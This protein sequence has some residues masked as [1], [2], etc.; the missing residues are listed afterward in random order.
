[1][2]NY[3]VFK[4]LCAC[5]QFSRNV[6]NGAAYSA[7]G[8]LGEFYIQDDENGV[9]LNITDD[10]IAPISHIPE[11]PRQQTAMKVHNPLENTTA[12]FSLLP[13]QI[14]PES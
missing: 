6:S 13:P 10:K 4:R 12:H 1:M 2:G 14:L 11:H 8:Q 9:V 5:V 7:L 3:N